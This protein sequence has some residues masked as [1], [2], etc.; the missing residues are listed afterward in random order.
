MQNEERK[1][2]AELLSATFAAMNLNEEKE[3]DTFGLKEEL[4]VIIDK[5]RM[6]YNSDKNVFT[7]VDEEDI[8]NKAIVKKHPEDTEDIEKAMLYCI[9]KYLGVSPAFLNKKLKKV[10]MQGKTEG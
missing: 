10:H 4:E 8:S 6:Y 3:E 7:I 2:L 9:F 5:T 1:I